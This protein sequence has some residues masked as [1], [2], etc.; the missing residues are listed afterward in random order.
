MSIT[1]SFLPLPIQHGKLGLYIE[2]DAHQHGQNGRD[3]THHLAAQ[4]ALQGS[5]LVL[6]CGCGFSATHVMELLHFQTLDFAEYL[7]RIDVARA[8]TAYQY[9]NLI[10][11]QPTATRPILILYSLALLY[12]DNLDLPESMRVLALMIQQLKRLCQTAPLLLIERPPPAE[13]DER[14]PLLS[15]LTQAADE[16]WG[17]LPAVAGGEQLQLPVLG[18][19]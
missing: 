8:F 17:E 11:K 18:E 4:L 3:V 16:V 12:D 13:M 10:E 2:Q 5:P 1:P 6:D 15:R 14:R 19:R 7:K 9:Q